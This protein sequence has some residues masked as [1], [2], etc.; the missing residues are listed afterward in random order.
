MSTHK[1]IDRICVVAVVFAL[2]VSMVF[3]NAESFGIEQAEVS[4]GYETRLFDTSVVHTIDIEMNDWDSFIETC[5][6]EEY[7]V[8]KV[9][10]DGETYANVGIRA[11]GNTSLTTVSS[12]DSDRYSFKIEF[13]QYDNT[14]SYH[15]LDKLSLNNLIQDNTMMKDYLTYQLMGEFGV[16]APLCSYTYI[17]VNGEDWGLYLAVEGVED[18]FLERNYGTDYGELYKPDSMS[19]GGGRG[20]GQKFSMEDFDFATDDSEGSESETQT[21]IAENSQTENDE[22]TVEAFDQSGM[23]TPPGMSE[24]AGEA[25]TPPGMSGENGEAVDPSQMFGEDFEPSQM[26]GEDG[27]AIDPTEIF[28]EDGEVIDPSEMFGEGS[29]TMPDM[30]GGMGSGMGSS[31]VK[32]QYIDD[33]ASSYS[34]IFDNAK[35][36]ITEADQTRL[37][38]SLKSLSEYED[39]ESV[40][41]VDE[42][43]RYFVVH[44]FVCNGDSYTGSMIHNYYLYEEDGQMSMIPWD[45][46][47]AFGGFQSSNATSTVN[48]P[49]DTPVSG[50]LMED[51]P[52]VNWIFENEEYTEMYHQYFA[53]FLESV[54]FETVISETAELIAPYVE[55]DPSKFCTYEE[56]ETGV[57]TLKEF[58][59]LREES[60]EGQLAGTIPSTSDGQS[61]DSSA[62][63]D[64]SHINITDMG[65]MNSTMGGMGGQG[66][67]MPGNRGEG[68][69]D[70]E[71]VPS[72]EMPS[73]EIPSA[74]SPDAELPETEE[75][76]VPTMP[77]GESGTVP[78]MPQ[79]ESG[80][81]PTIPEGEAGTM[82]G[83]P[84]GDAGTMQGM[85][86]DDA[87]TM[88]TMPDG[89]SGTMPTMPQ[90]EAGTMQAMPQGEAGTAPTMP[91][92]ESGTV[93]TMPQTGEETET[94]ENGEVSE[95]EVPEEGDSASANSEVTKDFANREMPE[96]MEMPG[97]ISNTG[98][99]NDAIVV[100]I[101]SVVILVLG[102]VF[103]FKYKRCK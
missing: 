88:Q 17:T 57:E 36:D 21:G 69:E 37:I 14:K 47:L 83:M 34:N 80:T 62:L 5:E 53:E 71:E 65:S 8:C 67:T 94:S 63:I 102:L 1:Y 38:E 28:G 19:F 90:G 56:F 81:M 39:I 78:T 99:S 18:A 97:E 95:V 98:Q 35:T 72:E 82:Q 70:N 73:E 32:L 93:P 23:M 30:G 66:M 31:D 33:D 91:D 54:D 7:A 25:M 76:T 29:T 60:I 50:G 46:N 2:L 27:E 43:I 9:V 55:Q 96:G 16:A 89:E 75:G 44:N 48:E 45:Y 61:A 24:E 64:A 103:V 86:Q 15:G 13:D 51:R 77:Q 42:V 68:T 11:K 101:V 58:C 41:N 4:L 26:F 10:I 100:M 52:M 85:P 84:Q 22:T 12:M 6:N 3:M 20:N 59:L 49:I 79:G 92:G 40:V 74:E 87:G